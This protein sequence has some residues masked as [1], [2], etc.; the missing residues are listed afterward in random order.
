MPKIIKNLEEKIFNN[1]QKLFC[2]NGYENV[3]MKTIAENCSIAVGT[4]Y[5]YFPNKKN[6]I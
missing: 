1:A 2:E 6:Y 3:D 4:L 5:N